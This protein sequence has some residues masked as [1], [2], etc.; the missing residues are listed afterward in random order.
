MQKL[1]TQSKKFPFCKTNNLIGLVLMLIICVLVGFSF[2]PF[3][4]MGQPNIVI[5]FADDMGY[6]DISALNPLSKISTPAIDNLVKN[7]ISFQNAHASASVCTPSRYGLLTGRYAFRTPKASR[8]IGGFTSSVIEKDRL[9]IA[10]I[11]KKAGYTTA[12]IGKWHLGLDW[13]TKDNKEAQLSSTGYSNVDYSSPVKAGP[14]DFGFDYSFIHPASLDIPPYVFLENGKVVDNEIGLTTDVYPIR[15]ENTAFSW[16]KKH[17]DDKAVY[18]EKGVWWR[19][20]EMSESFRV[21]ECLETIVNQ[22]ENFIDQQSAEKPFFLYMPLTGP[23]TPWLPS[24]ENKG[25]S[26]A[27]LYGDF[28][29]DIDQ[30]VAR[31]KSKLEAE[32]L[33]ENTLIIFSSDNGAYWPAEEILLHGHDSNKGSRGQKGDVWNGGHRVPLIMSWPDGI[34]KSNTYE[35]LVSLTDI[36]A[37]VAAMTGVEIPVG[38]AIDSKAFIPVLSGDMTFQTRDN[39]VHQ[40]S[41][42]MYAITSGAWKYIDGLGSGGFTFPTNLT[43]EPN[44]PKG[45]LYQLSED[46]LESENLFATYPEMIP[47]LKKQLEAI[48]NKEK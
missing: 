42:G 20:G 7:G 12:I 39:M 33:L 9:T 27:G 13:A 38:E 46:P 11:L 26:G 45:Q 47:S 14:N 40:S 35:G 44:G 36:Y 6:G 5:I 32:G 2:K 31:I 19:L 25:K 8:G 30:V 15:K 16:D 41:G 48:K 3:P 43:P 37:T 18:W 17:S 24:D 22:G 29:M 10:G 21:E 28:V 1:F 23:H 4:K 34:K